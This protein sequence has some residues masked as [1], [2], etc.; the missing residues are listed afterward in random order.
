VSA[1]VRDPSLLHRDPYRRGWL[2]AIEATNTAYTRLLYGEPAR[3]F[4]TQE[5]KRLM[6]F[7]DFEQ[8]L[9]LHAADGGEFVAPGASFLDAQQWRTLT[10]SFLKTS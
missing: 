1:V 6:R 9:Q 2:V 4:L 10:Q 7:F 3:E 8:E 5:S